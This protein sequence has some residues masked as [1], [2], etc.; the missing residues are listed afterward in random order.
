VVN[1]WMTSSSNTA[2]DIISIIHGVSTNSRLPIDP[3]HQLG[4][5]SEKSVDSADII[6]VENLQL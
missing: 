6:D 3:R 4:L 5:Q 2:D 1:Q